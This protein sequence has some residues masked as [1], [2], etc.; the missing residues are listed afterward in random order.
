MT[1]KSLKQIGNDFLENG[2]DYS[3]LM[4][5]PRC[6]KEYFALFDKIFIDHMGYCYW[7]CG[8]N[9]EEAERA[10]ENVLNLISEVL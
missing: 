1:K 3:Y 7:P 5:C 2:N 9:K 8:D 4:K 10:S 6:G